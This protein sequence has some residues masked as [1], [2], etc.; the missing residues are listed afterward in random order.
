MAKSHGKGNKGKQNVPFNEQPMT[1]KGS[2][3]N[4]AE[5]TSVVDTA[6]NESAAQ[7]NDMSTESSN[8]SGAIT[9]TLKRIQKNGI[10]TY[11]QEGVNASVYFNKTM[12]VGDPP[13]NVQIIA[14]GLTKPGESP[15]AG[16]AV[17][18]TKLTERATKAQERAA[19]ALERA[20]KAKANAEKLAKRAGIKGEEVI[21]EEVEV[22]A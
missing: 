1:V 12:F 19:K 8:G 4:A 9:L 14:D 18:Q 22:S 21:E 13:K 5:N 6:E 15:V 10:A 3:P 20:N 7:E 17:D 16:R 2:A 11:N